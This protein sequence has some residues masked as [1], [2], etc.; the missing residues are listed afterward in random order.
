MRYLLTIRKELEG[1]S[2]LPD[3]QS[4]DWFTI[5]PY[6]PAYLKWGAVHEALKKIWSMSRDPQ[7]AESIVNLVRRGHGVGEEGRPISTIGIIVQVLQA[8]KNAHMH[9]TRNTA[10]KLLHNLVWQSSVRCHPKL[11]AHLISE[12]VA[13]VLFS[14]IVENTPTEWPERYLQGGN[15]DSLESFHSMRCRACL[16]MIK[17]L[18]AC[19]RHDQICCIN[20]EGIADLVYNKRNFFDFQQDFE[21][22]PNDPV[23][24]GTLSSKLGD[25]KSMTIAEAEQAASFF[26]T[27]VLKKIESDK[28]REIRMKE[29][30]PLHKLFD[31]FAAEQNFPLKKVILTERHNFLN[32]S[33]KHLGDCS[34]QVLCRDVRQVL[35]INGPSTSSD[36]LA[37]M[38]DVLTTVGAISNYEYLRF[39]EGDDQ[40]DLAG[41]GFYL[42]RLITDIF[43]LLAKIL[44]KYSTDIE[45]FERAIFPLYQ[46]LISYDYD[47]ECMESLKSGTD[48]EQVKKDA[49]AIFD[50]IKSSKL[51][52]WKS[53]EDFMIRL[54]VRVTENL[55]KRCGPFYPQKESGGD[56]AVNV[57]AVN[58]VNEGASPGSAMDVTGNLG[59]RTYSKHVMLSYAHRPAENKENVIKTAKALESLGLL[60]WRDEEGN[61]YCPAMI[62]G[63]TDN[64]M[65]A[66][67]ENSY[68][69]VCF[70]SKEY[71]ESP[72]CI[73]EVLYA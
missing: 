17:I 66:A 42:P 8:T 38:I 39:S 25:P 27:Q 65:A 73:S 16:L 24:V 46:L 60:V 7:R 10:V 49:K 33:A 13:S 1:I 71:C 70:I 14:I 18:I 68:C 57:P 36:T 43:G 23:S 50:L 48:W 61:E 72:N 62:G 56:S 52:E 3:F 26:Q 12:N 30:E 31:E 55:D 6:A 19:S 41:H 40:H 58:K 63:E 45:I 29:Q 11:Y 59:T 34:L 69:V 64:A 51:I 21:S 54:A 2:R 44:E 20:N 4:I 53:P 22:E 9:F 47:G 15:K 67:V 32:T 37:L 35:E 28:H 5:S